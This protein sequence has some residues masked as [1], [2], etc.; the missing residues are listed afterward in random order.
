MQHTLRNIL[1]VILLIFAVYYA[2]AQNDSTFAPRKSSLPAEEQRLIDRV[3]FGGNFSFQF[4][5]VTFIDVSPLVFYQATPQLQVGVGATYQYI[6]FNFRG[7][8]T[9][10]NSI[11]GGRVFGR[12][13]P[14]ASSPFF[15][16]AEYENLN[17][18]YFDQLVG[19]VRRGWVPGTFLGGGY[20]QPMGRRAA[21]N[22]TV[23]YNF[24]W[25][26]LRSPYASPWVV[27][28]GFHL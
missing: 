10:A 5:N 2:K 21:F 9:T 27:R 20:S 4:G 15:A 13:F 1:I 8:N 11:Y 17:V 26:Q 22:L 12:F 19:E 6:R 28:A 18:A 24:S 7:F 14:F 23:L 16:H 3:R 25:N